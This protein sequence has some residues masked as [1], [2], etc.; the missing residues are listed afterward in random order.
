MTDIIYDWVHFKLPW[1]FMWML[2]R[3]ILVETF[4]FPRASPASDNSFIN[5]HDP[6]GVW[7]Y[8][9]EF[10]N[11]DVTFVHIFFKHE[12]DATL[13]RLKFL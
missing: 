1:S 13:F 8:Y 7:K 4:G 10:G 6:N 2:D 5:N 12:A 11:S 9:F 3:D